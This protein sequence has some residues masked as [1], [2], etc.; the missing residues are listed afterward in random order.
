MEQTKS[1][2]W[3]EALD[4]GECTMSEVLQQPLEVSVYDKD[5][6]KLWEIFSKTD[7]LLCSGQ[8]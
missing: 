5:T 8:L 6:G 3:E 2:T 7:D 1:P 4:F